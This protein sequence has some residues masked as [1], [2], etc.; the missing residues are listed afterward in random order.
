MGY[1][2]DRWISDYTYSALFDRNVAIKALVGLSAPLPGSEHGTVAPER[3]RV[4]HLEDG[5]A[6]WGR[7]LTFAGR[8]RGELALL[9]SRS[10]ADEL[11]AA[12]AVRLEQSHAD[13]HLLLVPESTVGAELDV[14]VD[15]VRYTLP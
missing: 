7:A 1:C 9:T 13:G 8:P 5:V 14:V 3:M 6:R 10:G 12:V 2:S 4:L 15:G 11:I